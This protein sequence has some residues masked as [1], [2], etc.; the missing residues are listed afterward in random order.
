[1]TKVLFRISGFI[2]VLAGL[3]YL[4]LTKYF[5]ASYIE[6]GPWKIYLFLIPIT[7]LGIV[8]INYSNKKDPTSTIKSITLLLLVKM[9]G[10]L[11]FLAPWIIEKNELTKPMVM[12]FFAVFFPIL[13]IET[14]S[15]IQLLNNLP[16][17]IEKN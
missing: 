1:M 4:I 2:L 17:K 9:I 7:I 12:Q 13:L 14:V 3:H 8:Y 6:V 5:P 15:L 16:N 10:S 11:L